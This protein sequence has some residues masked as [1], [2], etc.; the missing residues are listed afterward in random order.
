MRYG[1][2]ALLLAAAFLLGCGDSQYR[3]HTNVL[4]QPTGGT[5]SPGFYTKEVSKILAVANSSAPPDATVSVS[6]V[7][8]THMITI[9]VTMA[10]PEE[11]TKVCN[12]IVETY[13]SEKDEGVKKTI[14]EPARVPAEPL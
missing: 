6:Q 4:A 13:A 7:K 10:D 2:S 5:A 8:E 12:A 9:A 3:A 14:V 11:A 1:S